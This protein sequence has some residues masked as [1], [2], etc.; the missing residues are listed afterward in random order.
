MSIP[1]KPIKKEFKKR[2]YEFLRKNGRSITVK[3]P[4]YTVDCPNCI[5]DSVRGTSA[6]IYDPRFV[7][8]VNI[9]PGTPCQKTVY[10]APFNLDSSPSGIQY[11]PG[12]LDPKPIIASVCPVCVGEGKLTADNTFC[13]KALVTW[14]PKEEFLYA[15]AG[16]EG[17]PICRIKT[18]SKDYSLCKNA[19]SFIVDGV[20]C[21]LHIPPRLKGL[22]A[23]HITEFYLITTAVG[24]SVSDKFDS[25]SRLNNNTIGRVSDQADSG[26]PTV[27]PEV[28]GDDVW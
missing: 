27:P 19:E 22:G 7:R 4:E 28:P 6:N 26:T 10:P 14:D 18:F 16:D 8:P 21:K 15:S 13:I 25:D 5:H 9:F 12:I 17:K 20:S 11:D 2:F 3:L 24:H 1:A 23:D